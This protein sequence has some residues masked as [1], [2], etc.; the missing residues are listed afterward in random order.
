VWD[1]WRTTW[2]YGVFLGVLCFPLPIFNPLPASYTLLSLSPLLRSLD[3]SI[4][5]K[6][7]KRKEDNK[8]RFEAMAYLFYVPVGMERL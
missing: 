7:Q 4:V 1:L 5:A 6:E 3:N 8:G 2:E